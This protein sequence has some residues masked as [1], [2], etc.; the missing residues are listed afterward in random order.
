M[1]NS[2]HPRCPDCGGELQYVD[3]NTVTGQT[4]YEYRCD[5]CGREV[6]EDG[7]TALWQVLHDNNETQGA[8]PTP[9]PQ[10]PVAVAHAK[11]WWKF[12]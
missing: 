8:T 6:V 1:T 10:S 2:T 5:R 11:P 7:G 12:W 9:V 3:K 4:F